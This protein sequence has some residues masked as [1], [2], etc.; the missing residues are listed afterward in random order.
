MMEA[1][2]CESYIKLVRIFNKFNN[3]QKKRFVEYERSLG[4]ELLPFVD[5]LRYF[6]SLQNLFDLEFFQTKISSNSQTTSELEKCVQSGL[7]FWEISEDTLIL[8]DNN[9]ASENEDGSLIS[10]LGYKNVL[11]QKVVERIAYEKK[12]K[13]SLNQELDAIKDKFLNISLVI[14][15]SHSLINSVGYEST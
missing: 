10:N 7:P 11:S 8:G 12:F 1:R 14:M 5:I 2:D 4:F 15:I 9:F 13:I 3:F 6:N